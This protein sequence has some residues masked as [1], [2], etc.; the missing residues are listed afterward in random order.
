VGRRDLRDWAAVAEK[1]EGGGERRLGPETKRE[2]SF[3]LFFLKPKQT[4]FKNRLK[5]VNTTQYK[6]D[7]TLRWMQKCS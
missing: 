5:R 1:R 6:E 2:E 7:N 3:F 4:K